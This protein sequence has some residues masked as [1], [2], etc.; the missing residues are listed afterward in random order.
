MHRFLPL[1][2][3]LTACAGDP[4]ELHVTEVDWDQVD[5]GL[6]SV[7]F[8][9]EPLLTGSTELLPTHEDLNLKFSYRIKEGTTAKL[10]LQDKYTVG[11]PDL[12]VVGGDP[13]ILPAASPGVWQD[14]EVVFIA[15]ND[16]SPAL[17]PAV[18]LNGSLVYYQHEFA[19]DDR[20]A[21]PLKLLVEGG[22]IELK[23]LRSSDQGGVSSIMDADG[24]KLNIPL[25]RYEY[26]DL[27]EGVAAVTNWANYEP[28]KTGYINRFDLNNIREKGS[29]YGIRFYGKLNIPKAGEYKFL[30]DDQRV[31][32]DPGKHPGR[33]TSGLIELSEGT[34]DFRVDYVQSGGWSVLNVK[35]VAPDENGQQILNSMGGDKAIA[36]PGSSNPQK[37][38]TDDYPYLLRSF[39]YFPTPKVYEAANKR[40]HVIS[41]GE[42]DG[43]H[44]SLDLQNGALLQMWRGD[45][46][47]TYDMWV[48]RGEPQVMRPLGPAIALDGTPQWATVSGDADRWPESVV[49]DTDFQHIRH[50]LDEAG[51][52]T[53][54]YEMKGGHS[55]S[56]KLTPENGSL[57][58]ELTHTAGGNSTVYT[59][60]ATAKEIT[61]V[62]PGEY[63]LRGPGLNLKIES[64][65]GDR[66]VLQRANGKDRLLAELPAKGHITYRLNW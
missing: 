2:L 43:P 9:E 39:L 16:D 41:V 51:R 27:P 22:E 45:F 54:E 12:S 5:D 8:P 50:T 62:A 56:D 23:D 25:L 48:G 65:D 17:I 47:D 64:Y 34:H 57:L 42:G 6:V 36:G 35:Y 53:F 18:Y 58:R 11:L 7:S 13:R 38:E 29:G 30:A 33:E 20:P 63:A 21:G 40:T 32:H 14:L 61:E 19:A 52:P 31:I 55:L 15:A 66:L 26:F 10:M 24:V 44:Y 37:L 28:E 59:Q 3:L 46:A 1:L 4:L 49:E 60:L